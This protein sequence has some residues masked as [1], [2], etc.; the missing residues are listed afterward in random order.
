[1][2]LL[3]SIVAMA[4]GT[5]VVVSPVRASNIWA[6]GRLDKLEPP[7][8]TRFLRWYRVFGVVL[9]LGGLLSSVDS[10]AF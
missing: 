8:R 1:M 9:F 4:F 5:F 3:L 2:N 6:A 7:R 10:V